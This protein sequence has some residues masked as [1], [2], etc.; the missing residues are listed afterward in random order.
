[1]GLERGP[2]SLSKTVKLRERKS[3]G[4]GLE[5]RDYGRRGSAA[6][7]TRHPLSAN[8]GTNFAG[9]S[10]GVLRSRTKATEFLSSH[11]HLAFQVILFLLTF[12]PKFYFYFSSPHACYMHCPFQPRWLDRGRAQDMKLRF[13]RHKSYADRHNTAAT[14]RDRSILISILSEGQWSRCATVWS[15]CCKV[16]LLLI[17]VTVAAFLLASKYDAVFLPLRHSTIHYGSFMISGLRTWNEIKI[18]ECTVS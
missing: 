12:P 8:V 7:T 15:A 3:S 10:V 9:R 6:L 13:I 1:V 17:H 11:P 14:C 5:N 2:L 18:E 4:S 16:R